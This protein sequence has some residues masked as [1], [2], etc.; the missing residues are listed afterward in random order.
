[1][2]HSIANQQAAA[3]RN[4]Y[5]AV[6]FVPDSEIN[7]LT[8]AGATASMQRNMIIRAMA[9]L[10]A[11]AVKG[12][13]I[14]GGNSDQPL[15]NNTSKSSAGTA[16]KND[17]LTG[18]L[19]PL[20]TNDTLTAQI[21]NGN[22]SEIDTQIIFLKHGP[23]IREVQYKRVFPIRA[24]SATTAVIH[25]WTQCNLALQATLKPNTLY[26]IIGM[27]AHGATMN[28]ARL[29]SS[30]QEY[31]YHKPTILA[32]DS[33]ILGSFFLFK[34][35]GLEPMP[36]NSQ[37]LPTAEILCAVADTAQTFTLLLGEVGP[38]KA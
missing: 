17:I 28:A 19:E 5:T 1:M 21:D 20:V 37:R 15:E 35:I 6:N 22:N 31:A 27:A 36:F 23:R 3:A 32:S 29:R 25:T 10:G 4:G 2:D 7:G 16:T 14:K 18:I 8:S 33:A 24:T 26:H 12:K 30:D 34:D 38:A 9:L 11:A 13:V